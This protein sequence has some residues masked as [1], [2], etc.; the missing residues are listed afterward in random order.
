V[1]IIWLIVYLVR[2]NRYEFPVYPDGRG[3]QGR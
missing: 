1:G 2:R 3:I